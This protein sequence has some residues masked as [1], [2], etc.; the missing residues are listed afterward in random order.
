MQKLG[1][2]YRMSD[3]Q[4]ALGISQL[5]KVTKSACLTLVFISLDRM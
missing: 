1:L 2:N 5:D 3:V 4:A